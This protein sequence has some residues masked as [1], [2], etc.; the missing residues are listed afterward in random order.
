MAIKT[1]R[2]RERERE[3]ET[4]FT[5]Y[6]PI[7]AVFSEY[8]EGALR[9][10]GSE[11]DHEGRLEVYHSGVWGT[12]CSHGFDDRDARVACRDLGFGSVVI[13]SLLRCFH[14]AIPLKS[15]VGSVL[16]HHQRVVFRDR[17]DN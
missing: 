14:I 4:V 15:R 1:E 6:V 3:R 12:V 10:E 13:L 7:V 17:I 8:E 5:S 16:H 2:E 9:L 11:V